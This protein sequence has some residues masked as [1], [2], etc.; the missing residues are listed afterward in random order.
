MA[1][2]LQ[3]NKPQYRNIG[4]AQIVKYRLPWAGRVSITHRISGAFLF[5]SLPF[6]LHLFEQSLAT[7]ATFDALKNFA[8][9]LGVKLI[10]LLLSAAYLF[11]FC[12]G[13]RHVLMDLHV[14]VDKEKGRIS[15]IVVF[16]VA[17]LLTLAVA[18][19]L[20]GAF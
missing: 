12:A 6:I 16:V 18:A 15:A 1:E 7:S 5:L 8:S 2:T 20:F 11:H 13:L 9:H 3:K 17:A 10:L 4:I 19:K 14:G